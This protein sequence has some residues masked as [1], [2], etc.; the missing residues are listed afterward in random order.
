MSQ[1]NDALP[2]GYQTEEL[3][4][5]YFLKAGYYV[6]RGVPFIY[7]NFDVTDIDIWLYS[8]NSPVSREVTIVDSK[9]KSTPKAIERIFWVKGLAIATKATNAIVATTEKRPEVKSFGHD[10]GVVVLDG[11]FINK[12][13][14]SESIITNRIS[15]EDLMNEIGAYEL[16]KLD[17]DWKGRMKLSKGL[18]ATTLSFDS[19]NEW[20]AQAQFF[21]EQAITKE[22]R[23]HTALR[24]LY[25][26]CSFLAVGIDYSMKEISFLESGDRSRIIKEGFT[27]GARG[28]DGIKK[29]INLAVGLVEQHTPG[30]A[31]ISGQVRNSVQN[32]FEKLNT[33]VLGEYFSKVE[34]TRTLFTVARD[35]EQLAMNREFQ[36]HQSS[37]SELR[38]MLFCLSDYWGI[39]RS[40][41]SKLG[42]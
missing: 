12:L 41:F 13:S 33:T 27:Y 24:C 14:T 2:K 15:D 21:A 26:I 18:L 1:K 5:N 3:L 10:L 37:S 31:K 42:S 35:L 29:I 38:G 40:V 6:V 25:L 32:E 4:R 23:R 7:E 16:N 11:N 36:S 20:L 34:V 8:R 19:C 30:G 39:D 28:G 9:N 17:G 22:H